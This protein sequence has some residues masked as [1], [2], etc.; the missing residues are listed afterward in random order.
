MSAQGSKAAIIITVIVISVS[1]VAF[2]YFI[3]SSNTSFGG[4]DVTSIT[5]IGNT[6]DIVYPELMEASIDRD[7]FGMWHVSASFLDNSGGWDSTESYERTFIIS[8]EN[9]TAINNALTAG[10]NLTYPSEDIIQGVMEMGSHIGFIIEVLY[11]DGTWLYVCTFQTEKGHI[12]VKSGRGTLDA[13][14][15]GP[16]FEP[17]AALNDFT[18]TVQTVFSSNI[19]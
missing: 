10:L 9:V 19:T 16:L 4:T 18:V 5:I 13:G 8:L 11:S 1:A 15:D 12:M 17:V 14:L 7:V 2:T 6:S 3:N